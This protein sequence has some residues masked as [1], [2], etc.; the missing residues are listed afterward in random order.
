MTHCAEVDGMLAVKLSDAEAFIGE[1]HVHATSGWQPNVHGAYHRSVTPHMDEASA[2]AYLRHSKLTPLTCSEENGYGSTPL[3]SPCPTSRNPSPHSRFSIRRFGIVLSGLAWMIVSSWA[4]LLNKHVMVGLGFRYPVTVAAMGMY[5]TSVVSYA[6]CKAFRITSQSAHLGPRFYLTRL[7]PTGFLMA[8][9]FQ[10]G[11]AGYLYLTVAF[12][13]MLKALCPVFTMLLLFAARLEKC[14]F[15]LVASVALIAFG[16]MIASYGELNLHLWGLLS[17]LISVFSESIRLV[18]TQVI[19]TG[20]SMHPLEGLSRLAPVCSLFLTMQAII[21]ELP[22]LR[23]TGGMHIVAQNPVPFII[24]ATMGFVVNA[25]ALLVIKLGSSLTLK[26][27]GT[28]KD[29]CLVTISILFLREAV[30]IVQVYGYI[31]SIGGFCWYNSLKIK[32]S[33]KEL[34]KTKQDTKI[35]G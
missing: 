22:A 27:L 15:Q 26:V 13:Q 21:F 14:T 31:I 35:I 6:T 23:R 5:T 20:N 34:P 3:T 10:T 24:A 16:V 25:F 32:P 12:V 1:R 9:T 30:S 17:M 19:L 4:I 11:N 28:F 8:V 2:A 7:L 18:L 29:A 33:I